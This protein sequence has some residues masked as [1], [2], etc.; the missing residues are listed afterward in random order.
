MDARVSELFGGCCRPAGSGAGGALRGRGGAAPGGGGSKAKKKNGRSRGGKTS[1]PPYLPPEVSSPGRAKAAAPRGLA[2][3]GA[4]ELLSVPVRARGLE[5]AE[6]W[7][8]PERLG[9]TWARRPAAAP[10]PGRSGRGQDWRQVLERLGGKSR[11]C[12]RGSCRAWAGSLAGSLGALAP[13]AMCPPAPVSPPRFGLAARRACDPSASELPA[14]STAPCP[15]V[16]AR[17]R[18]SV[19]AHFAVWERSSLGNRALLSS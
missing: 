8:S 12:W 5:R 3:K 4:A 13:R 15:L 6:G 16:V 2:P 10:D 14:W 11:R 9:A 7:S 19:C 17:S 18:A 1:N